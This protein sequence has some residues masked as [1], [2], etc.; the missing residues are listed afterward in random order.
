MPF[1]DK[2]KSSKAKDYPSEKKVDYASASNTKQD[3]E[4]A[5]P[6][7][8]PTD[9]AV[10]SYAA[11]DPISGE[12]A[13]ELN[14]A[15]SNLNLSPFP[16][17]FPEAEHCLVHLKLLSALHG[18][19]E[20]VGFT[21]GLFGIQD[22]SGEKTENKKDALA[23]LREKRWNLYVARA[24]ERFQEWWLKVLCAKENAVRM[25]T[26]AL[27]SASLQFIKFP[28]LGKAQEWTTAMLPPLGNYFFL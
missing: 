21:D 4:D 7:Y 28:E 16:S 6:T 22:S 19:K 9:E 11:T 5:P 3:K 13:A 26:G 10:P 2:L 1:F 20:E 15:F 8:A 14:S 24:V 12:A 18:L 27:G 17:P 25:T 23:T